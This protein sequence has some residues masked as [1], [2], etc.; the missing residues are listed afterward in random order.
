VVFG[1]RAHGQSKWA[2]S[3]M[4]RYRTIWATVVYIFKLRVGAA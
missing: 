2:Y 3:L 1:R 4:S